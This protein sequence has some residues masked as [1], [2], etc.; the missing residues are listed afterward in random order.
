M[1]FWP[2]CIRCGGKKPRASSPDNPGQRKG[3]SHFIHCGPSSAKFSRNEKRMGTVL[4][5]L[6]PCIIQYAANSKCLLSGSSNSRAS[7]CSL[8]TPDVYYLFKIH[9][10]RSTV[11]PCRGGGC[12]PADSHNPTMIDVRMGTIDRAAP[13]LDRLC[14]APVLFFCWPCS[15]FSTADIQ[16]LDLELLL[17]VVAFQ[18]SS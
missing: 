12:L 2:C 1:L 3:R 5:G 14:I 13:V 18:S 10:I 4:N 9:S 7:F 15:S 11:F 16:I 17:N 8:R 6:W